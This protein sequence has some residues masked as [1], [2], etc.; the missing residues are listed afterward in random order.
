MYPIAGTILGAAGL[1][2]MS[3]LPVGLPLWVPMIV[4]AVVG[5]GTGAFMSLI[6]TVVQTAAPRSAIGSVTASINLVRQ[7]GS[8]VATALIGTV[9]GFGV[10]G[11]LPAGL[12]AATLTPQIVH[13]AS[14]AV[15]SDVAAVYHDVYTP[16]FVALAVVY[17]LG[18]IA[19]V[20][21][22]HGRLSDETASVP[23][24]EPLNA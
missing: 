4:M 16:V 18:V 22:P 12:D 17:A 3:A 1:A 8:T 9:V 11:L 23:A 7:I 6:V 19:A 5:L 24:T 10:A 2:T 21:L 14:A 20:L 13:N 15:Q